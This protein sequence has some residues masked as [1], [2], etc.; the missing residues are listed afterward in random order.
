MHGFQKNNLGVSRPDLLSNVMGPSC[1]LDDLHPFIR[2]NPD[3]RELKQVGIRWKKTSTRNPK[4]DSFGEENT[5][6]A[7]G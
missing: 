3:G 7:L 1:M 4:A 2:S 6:L 5:I